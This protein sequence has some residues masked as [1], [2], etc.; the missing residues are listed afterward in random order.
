[1][2]TAKQHTAAEVTAQVKVEGRKA[3]RGFEDV[4]EYAI[5][6]KT[7]AYDYYSAWAEKATKPWT[8]QLFTELAVAKLRQR[9]RLVG[10]KNAGFIPRRKVSVDDLKL[11]QLL[12]ANV[13]QEADMD[14]QDAFIVALRLERDALRLYTDMADS[15]GDAEVRNAFLALA[16]DQAAHLLELETEYDRHYFGQN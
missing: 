15:A 9:E 3:L 5:N 10:L 8:K 1:M 13:V 14:V 12:T 4:M 16:Q 2:K 11:D 6:E 7:L